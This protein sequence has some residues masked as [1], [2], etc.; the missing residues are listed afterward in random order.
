VGS[1][2]GPQVLLTAAF[3]D[4]FHSTEWQHLLMG[5]L[6]K[7]WGASVAMLRKEPNNTSMQARWTATAITFL[8]KY[9][10]SVWAYQNMIVHGS[11]DQ[12]MAAKI[13]KA[14]ANKVKEYYNT[15]KTTPTFI[16]SHHKYL[17]TGCSLDQH[18]KLDIDSI[19][20]WMRYIDDAIQALLHHVLQIQT[21][22]LDTD[23]HTM[24]TYTSSMLQ[25]STTMDIISLSSSQMETTMNSNGIEN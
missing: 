14:S 1:L 17:F 3:T 24:T 20:C 25:S 7:H 15:F 19:N 4:Q 2:Q 23:D 6:S 21:I 8:W 22:Q 12:E 13:R 18:L 10:R 16:L 11:N 5:R 9:L